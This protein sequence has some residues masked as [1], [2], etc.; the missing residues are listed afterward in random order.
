VQVGDSGGVRGERL[1]EAS[2]PGVQSAVSARRLA[3]NLLANLRHPMATVGDEQSG[4]TVTADPRR[5]PGDMVTLTDTETGVSG[6][7]WRLQGVRHQLKGAEYAQ[8]V[9][10]RQVYPICVVGRSRIGHSLIGPLT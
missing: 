4:I 7:L 9:T 2:A 8:E 3:R 10:A 5:Q 6:G 1:L